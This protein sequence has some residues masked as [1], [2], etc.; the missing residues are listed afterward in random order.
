MRFAQRLAGGSASLGISHGNMA[1]AIVIYYFFEW[2]GHLFFF[3]PSSFNSHFFFFIFI[4]LP[5]SNNCSSPFLHG[6]WFN[7]MCFTSSLCVFRYDDI[8]GLLLK[9][10]YSHGH[11]KKLTCKVSKRAT[12]MNQAV[13]GKSWKENKI[14]NNNLADAKD[15]SQ[16]A[17][18]A[19]K[20]CIAGL[21]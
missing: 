3:S 14:W 7:T 19:M 16:L 6:K 20:I 18:S 5:I 11:S 17:Q 9:V 4:L 13:L 8:F 10:L 2:G 21:W 12:E 15:I 1:T